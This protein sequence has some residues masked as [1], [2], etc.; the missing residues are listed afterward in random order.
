MMS[1]SMPN[2]SHPNISPVR[3]KP[4]ITSSANHQAR[5]ICAALLMRGK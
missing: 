4:Q 5:R 1:G 2:V 3:P